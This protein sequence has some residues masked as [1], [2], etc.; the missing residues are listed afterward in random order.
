MDDIIKNYFYD[1]NKGF[2]SVNK[3]YKKLKEDGHKIPLKYVQTFYDNQQVIQKTKRKPL[4]VDRVYNTIIASG[5]RADY[6]IDIIVYDRFEYHHY[7]YILCVID[8]Y[9]RYASC[10]AMTNRKNETILEELKSIFD[11]G[12]SPSDQQR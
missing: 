6:Q 12:C 4:K 3:L 8:V 7:K 9:S 11:E 5:Y 10:R 1:V 2:V